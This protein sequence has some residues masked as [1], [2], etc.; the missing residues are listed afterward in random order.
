MQTVILK[1]E[2]GNRFG[3]KWNVNCENSDLIC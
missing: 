1:G 3:E 2:L